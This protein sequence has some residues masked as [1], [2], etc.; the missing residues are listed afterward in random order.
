MTAL[1]LFNLPILLAAA[2]IVAVARQEH[3]TYAIAARLGQ[4]DVS[5][6]ARAL[7]EL[8][9]HLQQDAGAV[10][11]QWIAAR[12]AAMHQVEQDIETLT[13]DVVRR[14]ALDVRNEANA[15][16]V[17]FMAWVVESLA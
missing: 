6:L 7:E 13:D 10:A 12:R 17:V 15:A 4:L 5:R 14:L 2:A 8:V 3:E 1:A 16:G 11:R 9:R